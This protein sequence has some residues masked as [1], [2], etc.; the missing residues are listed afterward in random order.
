MSDEYYE[1]IHNHWV[2]V[3][4]LTGKNKHRPDGFEILL[5]AWELDQLDAIKAKHEAEMQKFLK[6]LSREMLGIEE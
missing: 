1:V 2:D 4:R 6:D 5:S 3:W